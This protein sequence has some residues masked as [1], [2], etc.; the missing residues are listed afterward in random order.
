MNLPFIQQ[1]IKG[2]EGLKLSVYPDTRGN[3]TIGYGFNLDSNDAAA[4]CAKF[5][6][7][8]AG[9]IYG[10]VNLTQP[11]A[12]EIFEFQL[13]VVIGQAMLL[14]ST[15]VV[16]PDGVQAAICDMIFNMGLTRFNGF[17]DT[18]ADLKAVNYTQAAKDALDSDWAR[19]V[20]TRAADDARLLEAV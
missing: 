9:L 1:L 10:T 8:L 3:M 19:E 15:F 14:F 20:P 5:G 18:I 4:I 16:M 17:I 11:Q 13:N 12:D 7:D 2:H 6:L